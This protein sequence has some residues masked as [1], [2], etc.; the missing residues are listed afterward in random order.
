[1]DLRDLGFD[2]GDWIVFAQ[3]S[4]EWRALVRA[5]MNLGSLK[6]KQFT[7]IEISR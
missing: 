7:L 6:S 3:D 4:N 5:V 1:M 2:A